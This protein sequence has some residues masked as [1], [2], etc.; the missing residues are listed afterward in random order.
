MKE[1]MEKRWNGQNSHFSNNAYII[2]G[3]FEPKKS[4]GGKR[5]ISNWPSPSTM[6][7]EKVNDNKN[8]GLIF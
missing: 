8:Y 1:I 4:N 3:D 6:D 7:I 2:D 5:N